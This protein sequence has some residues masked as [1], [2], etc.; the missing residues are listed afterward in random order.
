MR[1]PESEI[2]AARAPRGARGR[3][4]ALPAPQR[5]TSGSWTHTQG[6]LPTDHWRGPNLQAVT[7]KQRNNTERRKLNTQGTL[8][9]TVK[10]A[11]GATCHQRGR[12]EL[13]DG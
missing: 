7:S 6:A 9:G 10:G 2:S 13:G 8:R 12:S 1:A 5:D 4:A 3:P 11:G